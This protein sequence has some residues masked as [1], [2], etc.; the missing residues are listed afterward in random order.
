MIGGHGT[1]TGTAQGLPQVMCET[2]GS[3]GF[4]KPTDGRFASVRG[5][6]PDCGGTSFTDPYQ[7]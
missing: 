5:E 6:C 7:G 2:C 3:F 4:G 1:G